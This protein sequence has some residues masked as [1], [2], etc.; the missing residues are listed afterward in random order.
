[1]VAMVRLHLS[2]TTASGDSIPVWG[3]HGEECEN[4]GKRA[5]EGVFGNLG[6]DHLAVKSSLHKGVSK[7]LNIL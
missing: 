1:M 4:L 3:T 6:I 2:S 7:C 5:L